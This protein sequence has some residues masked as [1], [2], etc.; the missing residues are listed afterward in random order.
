MITAKSDELLANRTPAIG[1]P[2]ANLG[3]LRNTLHLLA[4]GQTTVSVST[5]AGVDQGLD[6]PLYRK[7]ARLLRVGALSLHGRPIVQIKT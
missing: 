6:A 2:F 5:L 1:L 7:L 3:V 4:A